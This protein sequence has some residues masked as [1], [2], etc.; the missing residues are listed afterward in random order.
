MA[1]SKE[2]VSIDEI[3]TAATAAVRP[4]FRSKGLQLETEMPDDLPPVLCDRTRIREVLLNLL[5]NAGRFTE[6]GGVRVCVRRE[7]GDVVFSVADTGP[8]IAGEDMNKIFLPFFQLDD[9]IRRRHGGSG[10]GLSISKSF[11]E[12]HG[13][14]MWVE[15]EKGR[16]TTFYFRLPIDPSPP[17]TD[18]VARWFSPYWHYEERTRRSLAPIST[19]RPRYVVVEPGNSLQRLLSRYLDNAE[20]VPTN[21]LDRALQEMERIPAQALLINHDSV[22]ETLQQ[23]NEVKLPHA[24]PVIVCS[25]PSAEEAAGELGVSSYLV[26]PISREVLL[27][28]LDRLPSHPR[29]VLVVDDEPE[30]LQL[31]WRMLASSGRGYRVLTAADGREALSILREERPDVLLL[32]L[33]MPEM[34]GFQLLE[35]RNQDP[36][37]HGI[38]VIVT[39]ARDPMGRSFVTSTLAVV[40]VGGLSTAQFLACIQGASAILSAG[41][42]PDDPKPKEKHPGSLA[43]A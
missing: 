23:L 5:S 36:A 14:Q 42:P 16:G 7:G 13:G 28:A 12:L 1:L 20:I 8:G 31:F 21:T 6:C 24:Q 32:D 29:T 26:K 34:D 43:S 30:A 9:S 11:V 15:S 19:V 17:T 18:S 33:A 10:L 38:P 2:R 25:L 4:L 22:A 40:Q 41:S 35:T 3:V 27:A 37:L 39:S